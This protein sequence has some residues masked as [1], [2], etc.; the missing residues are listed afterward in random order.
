[1]SSSTATEPQL[2]AV[3]QVGRAILGIGKTQEEALTDAE[4]W[5]KEGT[6]LSS[7]RFVRNCTVPGKLRLVGITRAMTV[8]VCR[9]GARAPYASLRDG[10]LCTRQEAQA[11]ESRIAKRVAKWEAVEA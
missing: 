1:M 8:E 3:E 9:H 4:E 10:T 5:V 6:D 2:F 7:V 11:E